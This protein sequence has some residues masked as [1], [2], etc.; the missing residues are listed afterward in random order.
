MSEFFFF[1]NQYS[2]IL[3]VNKCSLGHTCPRV[4]VMP[5]L[6]RHEL[7]QVDE[8]EKAVLSLLFILSGCGDDDSDNLEPSFSSQPP[9]GHFHFGSL[10]SF[11]LLLP[12]LAEARKS[13]DYNFFFQPC[14]PFYD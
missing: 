10:I 7:G 5:F 8:Q 12:N 1:F 2:S 6:Q 11:F 4:Q 3:Q 13:K 14:Y 9:S